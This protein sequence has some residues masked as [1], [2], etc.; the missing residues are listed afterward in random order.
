MR[1]SVLC[2][3]AVVGVLAGTALAAGHATIEPGGKI[4]V[5]TIAR[6]DRYSA[7]WNLWLN[8]PTVINKAGT[9]HKSCNIPKGRLY[10]GAED[11][12]P[13]QRKLDA[14]WKQERWRLWVDGQPV[15]LP[16][17]GASDNH[18]ALNGKSVIVRNWN[19]ILVDAPS[20]KHTVRYLWHVPSGAVVDL[21][22]AVT[23]RK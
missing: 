20:G 9:Y 12:S 4:G 11:W 22:L 3:L 7:N 21:T 2:G 19:V 5:M 10:I 1:S 15:D 14:I 8:C 6:G 18:R 17:F 16:R 13:S 23:I